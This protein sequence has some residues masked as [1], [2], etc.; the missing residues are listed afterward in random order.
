MNTTIL[1]N[2]KWDSN[3]EGEIFAMGN[4]RGQQEEREVRPK[5]EQFHIYTYMQLHIL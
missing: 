2:M 4:G 5:Q 3:A 1:L